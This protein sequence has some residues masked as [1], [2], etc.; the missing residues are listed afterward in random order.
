MP[1]IAGVAMILA[2]HSGGI[3]FLG[4]KFRS[5]MTKKR[6]HCPTKHNILDIIHQK[7]V[8][9]NGILNCTFQNLN[10]NW[11]TCLLN[12]IHLPEERFQISC[13]ANRYEM[14]SPAELEVLTKE[15]A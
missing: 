15:S 5:L 6:L 11:L 13:H 4:D 14:L 7:Q 8:E 12:P 2:K 3:Q 10:T 9:Q 1:I